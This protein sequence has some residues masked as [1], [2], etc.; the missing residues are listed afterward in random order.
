[1]WEEAPERAARGQRRQW[2]AVGAGGSME[3]FRAAARFGSRD[4]ACEGWLCVTV[5][6]GPGVGFGNMKGKLGQQCARQKFSLVL[7]AK[8]YLSTAYTCPE[9]VSQQTLGRL[10]MCTECNLSAECLA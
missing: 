2:R 5:T 3:I 8:T 6:Y 9:C 10:T 1:V 7:P 4:L